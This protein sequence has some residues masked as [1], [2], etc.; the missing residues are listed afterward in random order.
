[1]PPVVSWHKLSLTMGSTMLV[2]GCLEVG[3]Q[4]FYPQPPLQHIQTVLNRGRF[5]EP[6]IHRNIQPEFQTTLE[7]N[8]QGFVDFPWNIGHTDILLLGDSFV[9]GAQVSMESGVGRKLATDLGSDVKSIGVPGAGTATELLLLK[10]WIDVLKPTMVIVGFLPSNDIL[11]NHPQLESKSDKPFINLDT[12]RSSQELHFDIPEAIQTD[13]RLLYSSQF[14]RWFIR[15]MHTK[16]VI[17]KKIQKGDGI[18][19]DWQVYN[20]AKEAVWDEAWHITAALYA[21]ILRVCKASDTEFKVV[22]FPSIEEISP[23]YQRMLSQSY[24]E[25]DQ[26]SIKEGL[27]TQSLETL[28]KAGIPTEDIF[29]LYPVFRAHSAPDTLYFQRDHHWT[30]TGHAL[31]SEAIQTWLQ[32]EQ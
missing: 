9:Q 29:S 12:F 1:M 19:I 30:D 20:P 7:V 23:S 25:M 24:P 2:L 8:E 22:L 26:W 31:A 17:R 14:I 6:G 28:S 16:N 15:S 10:E 13:H 27:E 18:P 11:N 21:E 3:T 4:I 32:Q 5:T